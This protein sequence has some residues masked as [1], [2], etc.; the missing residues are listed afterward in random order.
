MKKTKKVSFNILIIV[1]IF[2]SI[3]F[4]SIGY[5]AFN[6]EMTI[7]GE[8]I[9]NVDN[10]IFISNIELIES[11]DSAELYAP[12]Y[13][14]VTTEIGI[15][16]PS[17]TSTFTYEITITNTSDSYYHLKQINELVNSNP[18]ITYLIYN[19][20]IYTEFAPRSDTKF[21]ISYTASG[22][23]TETDFNLGLEYVF[24]PGDI[25]SDPLLN[26]ADPV[27][28]DGL[29]P[30]VYDE[31]QA[32]WVKADVIRE[33]W[34]DYAEQQWANSAS[35]IPTMRET[36]VD[37]EP[38]TV[39]P[40]DHIISM[41][42][43]IP[44]YS[45][46][47]RDTLGYQGY[48]G[49]SVTINT[50]GAFDIE[51]HDTSI[52]HTGS[53]NY[54]GTT[55]INYYTSP[56]FCWGNTCDDP[57]TR[58]NSENQEIPG[59]W[60]AKFEASKQGNILYS[61]PNVTPMN[62]MNIANT[63]YYVQDLMNGMNGYN[64]YGFVGYV[65]AHLIKNTE[66]GAIA[67]LTQSMYGKY[68]NVDYT[69]I[70]KEVYPNNCNLYVTGIGGNAPS[71][72]STSTSCTTNT[73]ETYEGKGAST[74]GN[75]YGVY[76]TVGGTFDRVMGTVLDV[77]GNLVAGSSGFTADTLPEG[78]YINI[79]PNAHYGL[80]T[81][82][83]IKGD[84]LTDTLGFYQDR[85]VTS[86]YLSYSWFYR[87]GSLYGDVTTINGIFS[88]TTYTGQA[89]LNHSSRFTITIY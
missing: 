51:F 38:G 84:A 45:Y 59:F 24:S 52:I 89:D 37:A 18:S 77:N 55:A 73:Y 49:D 66:W 76:D 75:I 25:Y 31:N 46:T 14:N 32:T 21:Q 12:R 40:M 70:Y 26:G 17:G 11:T 65:D 83:S 13:N 58:T 19:L 16:V 48:G 36:Y 64:N 71:V 61:K 81:T 43:W 15:N 33:E 28:I 35:V 63:F 29:I 3:S 87:G 54:T 57:T 85:G 7:S 34:Y 41:M 86:S 62:N 9:I 60:I 56:A 79:Y 1:M 2:F 5:S 39:I 22:T 68:G 6:S 44:R 4:I 47:V 82:T 42:V 80:T 69:G 88:Y 72:T 23:P 10:K 30:I 50:P 53:A 20:Y 78:R 67:Y 27:L 8:A 74:T